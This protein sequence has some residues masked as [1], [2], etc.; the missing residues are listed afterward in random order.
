FNTLDDSPTR[1]MVVPEEATQRIEVEAPTF[2][3]DLK[4]PDQA[5]SPGA[6]IAAELAITNTGGE[7]ERYVVDFHGL[8]RDWV[9][10]DRQ[11][12]EIAP[13]KTATVVMSFKPLRRSESAPGDYQAFVTVRPNRD[14]A[15]ML[16]ADFV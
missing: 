14:G 5:V 15:A 11:T 1:P 7:T 2:R 4:G 3:I 16:N 10:I 8:P 12:V 9:R 6:H 13:D